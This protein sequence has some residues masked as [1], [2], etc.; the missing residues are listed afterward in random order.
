MGTETTDLI[1]EMVIEKAIEVLGSREDA[2]AWLERPAMALE[3]KTPASMLGSEGGR[4]KVSNLLLQ[5][6]FGVYV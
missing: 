1:R 3:Q 4:R 5:L 2:L 6:E